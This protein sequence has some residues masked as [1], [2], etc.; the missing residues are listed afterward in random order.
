MYK[1]GIKLNRLMNHT[2]NMNLKLVEC[3]ICGLLP[4]EI[5]TC[6]S[7]EEN[8]CGVCRADRAVKDK[9]NSC[10]SCFEEYIKLPTQKSLISILNNLV[11]SCFNASGGCNQQLGYTDLLKHEV[12]CSYRPVINLEDSKESAAL[13]TEEVSKAV[14][15]TKGSDRSKTSDRLIESVRT[16]EPEILKTHDELK[17]VIGTK[18]LLGSK[19]LGPSKSLERSKGYN[20]SKVAKESK[21]LNGLD[22]LDKSKIGNES[23]VLE[24]SKS[25][26]K[27]KPFNGSKAL[28][29]YQGL[30]EPKLSTRLKH[31]EALDDEV[32]SHKKADIIQSLGENLCTEDINSVSSCY[33]KYETLFTTRLKTLMMMEFEKLTKE[34]EQKYIISTELLR[35]EIELM[36]SQLEALQQNLGVNIVT[37][38]IKTQA[39]TERAKGIVSKYPE[40][41]DT[42]DNY[43]TNTK[44]NLKLFNEIPHF[45]ANSGS[46]SNNNPKYLGEKEEMTIEDL[47]NFNESHKTLIRSVDINK[48]SKILNSSQRSFLSPILHTRESNSFIFEENNK[49]LN[50]IKQDLIIDIIR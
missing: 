47:N 20:G 12:V 1:T 43:S 27:S 22:A 41:V 21:T 13:K 8:F 30:E 29:E 9:T 45:K 15:E 37:D 17:S 18:G 5:E 50:T 32:D 35:D 42:T 39:I 3:F 19:D 46:L 36:K 6:S 24:G 38:S 31:F 34:L 23:I 28:Y 11:I 44:Q 48:G 2:Q 25:S 14:L 26:D 16:K 40:K 33:K 49:G 4:Y 7:C 10:P